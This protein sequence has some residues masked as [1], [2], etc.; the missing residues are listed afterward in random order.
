M[1]QAVLIPLAG[2][3]PARHRGLRHQ[4]PRVPGGHHRQ[5]RRRRDT[6]RGASLP[7]VLFATVDEG[8]DR[9][10]CPEPPQLLVPLHGLGGFRAAL[11]GCLRGA[12]HLEPHFELG[13]FALT[14]QKA[15]S[16]MVAITCLLPTYPYIC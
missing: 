3:G 13:S 11:G 4:Q 7:R 14:T 15:M 1:D 2:L 9:G 6:V 10:G 5:L 16:S 8:D 12:R